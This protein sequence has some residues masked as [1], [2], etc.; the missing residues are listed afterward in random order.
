[1][2]C[3]CLVS[4]ITVMAQ[5]DPPPSPWSFEGEVS[6]VNA[7]GN[8]ESKTLGTNAQL[9]YK[10][11]KSEFVIRAGGLYQESAIKTRVAS[12]DSSGFAVQETKVTEKTAEAYYG[13]ARYDYNISERFL[14]FGGVDWLRNTF[15][16]ID[17]RTLIAA[18]AGNTLADDD[19]T[20]LKT[21]YSFTYTF[22]SDIVENPFVKADF[23]GVRLGYDFWA[24]FNESV[25]FESKLIFDM[26]L[27]HSDDIRVEFVNALPIRVSSVLAFKPS[28]LLLWRNEPSLTTVP[29]SPGPGSVNVPLEKLDTFSSVSLLVKI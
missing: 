4:T 16:G 23:P 22:Q 8:Q 19:D 10:K 26:N 21:Y 5:D 1:M 3:L 13:R 14:L 17:S 27:D 28:I 2:L 11:A 15:A 24:Q 18:G 6:V 25:E 7:G 9:T 20:K 29:L 12:G